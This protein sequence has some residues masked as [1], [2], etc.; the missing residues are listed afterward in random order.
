MKDELFEV[1]RMVLQQ[2]VTEMGYGGGV[3]GWIGMMED[4]LGTD[5]WSD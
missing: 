3:D 5:E 1:S 4:G 2:A